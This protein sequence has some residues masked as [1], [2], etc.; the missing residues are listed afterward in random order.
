[1]NTNTATDGNTHRWYECTGC[2]RNRP[3]YTSTDP[4]LLPKRQ[5]Q[6]DL[7][8]D[9][10]IDVDDESVYA[11]R[12]WALLVFH[13][14]KDAAQDENVEVYRVNVEAIRRL[15]MVLGFVAKGTSFRSACPF[16]DVARKVTK[17]N[18]LRGCSES[19]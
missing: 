16:V 13:E 8:G 19:V 12:S 14:H 10:L 3:Q 18:Y 11:T 1:M 15:K 4:Q 2:W 17:L 5:V 7:I 6:H 9:L